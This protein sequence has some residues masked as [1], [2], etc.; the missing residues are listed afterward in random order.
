[1]K[2]STMTMKIDGKPVKAEE[3]MT[4]FQAARNAGIGIPSLCY[5]EKLEPFGACRF[6][7]IEVTKNRKTK[8]VASCCYPAE[9]GLVVK[10][11]SERILKIR[12]VILELLLPLAPSG[13]LPDLA[14]KYG[15][16]R[17][18]FPLEK[19][20]EITNCTLCG[21]CVRYCA[22]VK[23]LNAIGF[24]GR[25]V[26]RRVELM[27]E[28]GNECITCRECYGRDVCESGRFVVIAEEF[29]FLQYAYRGR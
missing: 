4:V 20:E 11:N 15:A 1:M 23:K 28:I 5:N 10:T 2:M 26:N 8:L 22:E 17:S 14:K 25:G 12:K 7:M 9:D 24:V 18:R 29:P 16:D 19:G 13:P 21:R 3:G 6:C 27:P